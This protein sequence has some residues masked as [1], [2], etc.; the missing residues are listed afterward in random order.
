MSGLGWLLALVLGGIVGWLVFR[1]RRCAASRK[2]LAILAG[3]VGGILGALFLGSWGWMVGG[4][5]V[6]A[7]LLAAFVLAMIVLFFAR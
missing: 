2:W 5:N 3:V 1:W 7:T 4:A 6:T